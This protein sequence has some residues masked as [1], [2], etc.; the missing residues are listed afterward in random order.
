[1]AKLKI[2]ITN[3]LVEYYEIRGRLTLGRGKEVDLL[4][5]DPAISREHSAVFPDGEE[6]LIEDL[7]SAN[8]TF[9]NDELVTK[10]PLEEGD[11]IRV[12]TKLI[13]FTREELTPV[14]DTIV[15]LAEKPA[16]SYDE[17]AITA[18]PDVLFVS[19]TSDEKMEWVYAQAKRLFLDSALTDEFG[20]GRGSGFRLQGRT[21]ERPERRRHLRCEG[22]IPRRGHG[23][24]RNNAH[25]P[26][27][28]PRGVQRQGQPGHPHEVPRGFLP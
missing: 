13:I 16:D 21:G 5:L 28:R 20:R 23:R 6:Y 1:M 14:A 24:T 12:G 17:N 8:G 19:P 11:L 10:K 22:E 26:L 15:D 18:S 7:G 9:V 25:G 2:V 4:L 3:K 27:R